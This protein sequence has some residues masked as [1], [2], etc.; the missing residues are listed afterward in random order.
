MSFF[1]RGCFSFLFFD[2]IPSFALL[3][4]PVLNRARSPPRQKAQS[5]KS[6]CLSILLFSSLFGFFFSL[7]VLGRLFI[8]A[9]R[10]WG[11]AVRIFGFP[12][13]EDGV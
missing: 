9:F 1:F 10:F 2:G 8:F 5:F 3:R 6:V 11:A 4:R 12:T 7:Y 13:G